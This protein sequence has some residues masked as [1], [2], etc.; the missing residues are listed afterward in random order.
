MDEVPVPLQNTI[1]EYEVSRK[2]RAAYEEELQTG[3]IR[4]PE[5]PKM[6]L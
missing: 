4:I 2:I 5:V 3:T 1:P 6:G